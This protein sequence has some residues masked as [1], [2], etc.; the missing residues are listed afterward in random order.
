MGSY[1]TPRNGIPKMDYEYLLMFKKLGKPAK[2]DRVAKA[3][4]EQSEM[5]LDEWKTYFTGHWRIP[6]ERMKG[7]P[8]MFPREIPRRFIK[9]FAFYGDTV[10]DPF[11][12]SGTTLSVAHELGRHSVGYELNEKFRETIERRCSAV[13]LEFIRRDDD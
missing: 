6:G 8:S 7:H 2:K 1:P 10:L 9:M 13:D 3:V 5:T 11:V 12:G 4:K